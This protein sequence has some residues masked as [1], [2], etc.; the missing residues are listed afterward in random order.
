VVDELWPGAVAP[1]VDTALLEPAPQLGG[2]ARPQALGRERVGQLEPAPGP[3]EVD[4]VAAEGDR[5]SAQRLQRHRLHELLDAGHRVAVVGVGLVPLE[6][7]ELGLVLVGEALVAEVLADLVHALQAAHDQ[8]LQ[9]ELGG[10]A[11][12]DVL[13]EG[14]VAGNEGLGE[15]ASVARLQDRRLHL[16]EAGLVQVAADRA[17]HARAQL[18]VTPRLLVDEQIEVTLAVAGLGVAQSV[19]GVWQRPADL[20]QEL[21]LANGQG[22][23]TASRLERGAGGADD[24]AE[25]DVHPPDAVLLAEELDAS[26]AIDEVEEDELAVLAAAEHAPAYAPRVVRLLPRLEALRLGTD[27]RDL[28][29]V[30]KAL[31]KAGHGRESSARKGRAALPPPG[32]QGRSERT[33]SS[34]S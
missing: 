1:G 4:L 16:E 14:V 27:R 8:P 29:P 25:V 26:R 9:I 13:V 28:V 3:P 2:V 32:P 19:E 10:D 6:H 18:E 33:T 5:R 17:H 22:R 7:R 15:G 20:G 30:G 24:V 31:G 12:V 21:K 11:Q 23:L 34:T